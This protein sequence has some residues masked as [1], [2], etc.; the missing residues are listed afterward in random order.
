M[1]VGRRLV[2]RARK[3]MVENASRPEPAVQPDNQA[4]AR[5]KPGRR[6]SAT[7]A[8]DLLTAAPLIMLYAAALGGLALR[9]GREFPAIATG[10]PGTTAFLGFLLDAVTAIYVVT[11]IIAFFI[12]KMP[13]AKADGVVPRLIALTGAYLQMS[14]LL[15]PHAAILQAVSVITVVVAML[16]TG[17]EIVILF[18]LRH[19]FTI[20]PEARVLVTGGPYRWVRHPI[21]L[22]GTINSFAVSLQFA[23]P[24]A[25]L[26]VLATLGFQLQRIKCEEAVLTR[27]FPAYAAYAKKTARLIPGIY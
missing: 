23:Q 2:C 13:V 6:F 1:S 26:I 11:T 27:A 16:G 17:A 4:V 7:K 8:Y 19:A 20:L 14:L 12:R 5:P 9:F 24:W 15:L 25:S 3:H 22:V 21:Y 18:R 10:H